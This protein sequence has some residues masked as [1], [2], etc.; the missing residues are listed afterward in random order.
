MDWCK[1]RVGSTWGIL[2]AICLLLAPGSGLAKP[3]V[4]EQG[5]SLIRELAFTGAQ[6]AR[7]SP[8]GSELFVGRRGT[9]SDGLYSIDSL[10]L[11]SKLAS[12]SNVAGVVVDKGGDAFFSEDYG[13]VIYKV[14]YQKSGRSTWVSGFH[15]GDDD[16]VG[17]AIA[18][19]NH[20]GPLLKPGEALVVDR[21]NSGP[22]EI[23]SWSPAKV[24]IASL[25]HK[26][27]GTLVDPVDVVIGSGLIYVVD[28]RGS[29][30]GRIYTVGSGGSL[31]ILSTTGKTLA[32]PMG[33]T[34]DP[35]NGDLLVVDRTGGKVVRV[36]D[37][38]SVVTDVITGMTIP[39]DGWASIDRSADGL[40]LLVTADNKIY[41]F[42]RCAVT[43]PGGATD[44]DG[45]G[46]LDACDIGLG[47][48][49]D[50]ND[51]GKPDTCDIAGS[52]STDCDNDKVPDECPVCPPVEAVFIMDT[53]SSMNDEAAALCSKIKAVGTILKGKGITLS[54]SALGISE[55]PGGAYSC[56]TNTVIK[57][58]GTSVPGSPPATVAT[59]GKCP[60]GNQVA[61]EDWGRATAVVAGV[62]SWG[63]GKVH[64]VIPISDE[65]P[66]CGDPVTDPGVDR[67]SI[68]HATKV[69]AAKSVIVSPITGTGSSS[70]MIKL[71]QDLAK[72]T[73]GKALSSKNPQNDMAK[74]VLEIIKTACKTFYDCNKN[75]TPDACDISKKKSKDC[76]YDGVPDECQSPIPTC[77]APD[78]GVPDA[79]L[80]DAALPDAV[81][82]DLTLPDTALPDVKDTP[83]PDAASPDVALPDAPVPDTPAPDKADTP[84]A[85]APAPD[86][87]S[88]DA[89]VH[90]APPGTPDSAADQTSSMDVAD[91]TTDGPLEDSGGCDC[92]VANS[93]SPS[94]TWL[95]LLALIIVGRRRRVS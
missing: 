49:K 44:C 4:V 11:E 41:L 57:V 90:D 20:V 52:S 5:W 26:D 25:V 95:L 46:K 8:K 19:S 21:G 17:M 63:T 28:T 15:A 9:S 62:K 1:T 67:D 45:N 82:P 6:S 37:S 40:R 73:G 86:A 13:G 32:N 75:G 94:A 51:N 89:A 87:A 76:D 91:S 48:H 24:G 84:P 68:T 34:L 69:A 78:A 18:P 10:G 61:S 54:S 23:W 27:N 64:L 3:V 60:G 56:L 42:A 92:S 80:P 47:S 93:V 72:G 33:A 43:P 83:P 79:T 65:G 53:S 35:K 85:D 71:A 88:P 70:G 39:G 58:H 81:L 74:S 12:G 31:A 66:W 77:A 2:I 29:S 30:A 36:D 55:A 50:C 14:T 38:T 7:F 16:P 22:D 59:L